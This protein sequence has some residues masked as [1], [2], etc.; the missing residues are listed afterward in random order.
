VPSIINQKGT[1]VVLRDQAIVLALDDSSSMVWSEDDFTPNRWREVV[2]CTKKFITTCKERMR[3]DTQLIIYKYSK[4][5]ERD[6]F[7]GQLGDNIPSEI[8]Q[9]VGTYTEYGPPIIKFFNDLNKNVG[10]LKTVNFILV[11]DGAGP[12]RDRDIKAITQCIGEN[13]EAWREP[14]NTLATKLNSLVITEAEV[15][16]WTSEPIYTLTSTITDGFKAKGMTMASR[17]TSDNFKEI[18]ELEEV[19]EYDEIDKL[20]INFMFPAVA[21]EAE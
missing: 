18:V 13:V 17:S 1:E 5:I 12:L 9:Q 4:D 8:W 15:F 19:E 6:T 2:D 3:G 21:A 11:T 14:M 16:H 10:G 7:V 20:M